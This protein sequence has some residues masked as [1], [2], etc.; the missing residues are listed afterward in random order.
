LN[1]HTNAPLEILKRGHTRC[2]GRHDR[3][4]DVGSQGIGSD[5]DNEDDDD[6]VAVVVDDDEQEDA[7]S[8]LVVVL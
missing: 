4:R 7:A 8:L 5:Y 3:N 1:T 2:V 6:V